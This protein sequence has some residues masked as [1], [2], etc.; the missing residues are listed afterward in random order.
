MKD[1]TITGKRRKKELIILLACFVTAFLLNVLA[2]IIYK[3]PWHE[4]FS[5]IGYVVVIT[6]VLFLIVTLVR[7]LVW[8]VGKLFKRRN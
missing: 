4:I 8:A 1:I 7:V 5:Q 6:L 3:T 2:V